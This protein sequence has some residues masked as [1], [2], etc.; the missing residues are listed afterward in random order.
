MEYYTTIKKKDPLPFET[1]WRDQEIIK[2]SEISL[3]EKDK[4]VI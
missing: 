1:V 3:P 2:L 4:Y